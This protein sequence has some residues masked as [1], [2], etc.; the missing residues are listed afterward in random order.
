MS[1]TINY[2]VTVVAQFTN[3]D[4]IHVDSVSR[5]IPNLSLTAVPE[6][7][8]YRPVAGSREGRAGVRSGA[9]GITWTT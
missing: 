8:I 2:L 6:G 9:G 4:L 1:D 5:S 3:R 7:P